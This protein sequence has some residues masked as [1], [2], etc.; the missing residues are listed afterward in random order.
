VDERSLYA[1]PFPFDATLDALSDCFRAQGG[2][3]VQC[4]RMRRHLTSKDFK[5]SCFVEFSSKEEADK[6]GLLK[7]VVWCGVGPVLGLAAGHGDWGGW[8]LYR[9]AQ[10]GCGARARLFGAAY[11]VPAPQQHT[12][13]QRL[14]PSPPSLP[15]GCA[16]CAC[17]AGAG[18]VSGV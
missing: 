13:G 11:N 16:C 14:I 17:C 10:S 7:V 4:V 18:H 5:G 3:T 12:N 8:Q 6:V 1:A 15:P 9:A 2:A